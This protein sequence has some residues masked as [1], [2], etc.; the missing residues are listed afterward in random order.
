MKADGW[1]KTIPRYEACGLPKA[2]DAEDGKRMFLRFLA[3][4]PPDR[5]FHVQA[6]PSRGSRWISF[7]HVGNVAGQAI[8]IGGIDAI[9]WMSI[10]AERNYVN[11]SHD[12][13][14]LFGDLLALTV[15]LG[16]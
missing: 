13:Q 9:S 6:I 16:V 8:T 5:I 10:T 3:E 1:A 7:S 12:H 15:S 2:I 4:S 11:V 14:P